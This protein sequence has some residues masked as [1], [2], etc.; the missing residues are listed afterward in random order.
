MTFIMRLFSDL[1][2]QHVEDFCLPVLTRVADFTEDNA[3]VTQA[4]TD[5]HFQRIIDFI[6][7]K[8]AV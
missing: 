6:D 5:H 7:E 1:G 4:K 8:I 3:E 2:I